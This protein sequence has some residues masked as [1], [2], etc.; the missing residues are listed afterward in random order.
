MSLN[1]VK[2]RP[3]EKIRTHH[4]DITLSPSTNGPNSAPQIISNQK[5]PRERCGPLVEGG[6]FSLPTPGS[7]AP[8]IYYSF[9]LVEPEP[10]CRKGMSLLACWDMA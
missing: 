10:G 3:G 9:P 4:K 6:L 8:S 7:T 1:K 2:E 5:T